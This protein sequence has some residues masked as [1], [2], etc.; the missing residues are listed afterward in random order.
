MDIFKKAIHTILPRLLVLEH[1][2][3]LRCPLEEQSQHL[4]RSENQRCISAVQPEQLRTL[5]QF[6]SN[7]FQNN[8]MYSGNTVKPKVCETVSTDTY[9]SAI[10]TITA[11]LGNKSQQTYHSHI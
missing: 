2:K 9:R 6:T 3:S 1:C 8:T 11:A 4:K 5:L 7:H 10:L